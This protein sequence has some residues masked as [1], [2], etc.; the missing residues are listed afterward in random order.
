MSRSNRVD[1]V[2]PATR[3]FQW[4]GDAGELSY[5]DK[6]LGEKGERVKVDLPFR[7][8]VLD[9]LAGA[10]GGKQVAGSYEGYWSNAVRDTKRQKLI[11]RSKQGIV[12]RGYYEDIKGREG[13]KFQQ[14]VYI[15]FH[16]ENK[17]LQIGCLKLSGA[18]VSAWFE[19]RNQHKDIYDGA[20]SITE[21]SEAKKN[22]SV[23]YYEP[24]FAGGVQVSEESEQAAI[25]LDEQLQEYLT[26]YFAQAG[27]EEVEV[28]YQEGRH[29]DSMPTMTGIPS[30]ESLVDEPPA[31]YDDEVPF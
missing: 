7:F 3:F 8:L 4:K 23:T 22:G 20:I 28:E 13:I 9:V 18:A 15:A 14:F 1:V 30:D 19:Y 11:V 27:I 31:G 21:R 2:N 16:D 25:K 24:I 6:S 17:E 26:A 10:S 12:A 5:F 29:D